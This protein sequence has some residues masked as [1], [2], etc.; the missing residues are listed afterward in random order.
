MW[1]C[2]GC[3]YNKG[4]YPYR[5][6]DLGEQRVIKADEDNPRRHLQ[7]AEN[8]V[9][10]TH[11]TPTGEF[12]IQLLRLNRQALLRLRAARRKLS[13]SSEFVAHGMAELL[14][15]RLDVFEARYRPLLHQLRV[16]I[17]RDYEQVIASVTRMIREAAKSELLDPDPDRKVALAARKEY[18]RSQ[19]AIGP[20]LAVPR[21][22]RGGERKPRQRRRTRRRR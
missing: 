6:R 15:A 8:S 5:V 9:D 7:L 14:S 18:L 22:A 19:G 4:D 17:E 20:G 3:N 10:L 16:G 13:E 11:K 1:S 21:Q 2:Q 12:N